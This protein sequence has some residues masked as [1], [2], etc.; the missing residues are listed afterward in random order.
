M[1]EALKS[2]VHAVKSGFVNVIF[3]TNNLI[4]WYSELG[5]IEA[6]HKLF[7]EMSE[8]NVYSW[9]TLIN[10]YIKSRNLC[11][12]R[13]LFD[14]CSCRDTVTYNSMIS[15]YARSGR[16]ENEAIALLIQMQ[17]D[18]DAGRI[19]EFTLTTML[20]MIAKLRVFDHGRQLHSFMDF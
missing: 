19:D 17:C 7:D 9:N 13:T 11:K 4:G 5:S 8:R 1:E 16:H 3:N 14:S 12:A 10:A 2:H 18:D 6:A 20:N 15:G